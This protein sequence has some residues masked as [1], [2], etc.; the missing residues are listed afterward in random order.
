VR[1]YSDVLKDN[2]VLINTIY[3]NC[4]DYCPLITNKL[5]HV[6][7]QLGERFG[8]TVYFVSIST[9]PL[10][11]TPEALAGFA[12]QQKADGSGW[13]F[14]TGEKQNIET[15]LRKLGQFSPEVESHSTLLLAGNVKAR[16]WLKIRPDT[17]IAGIV[18]E[19]QD[20]ADGS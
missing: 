18:L 5:T 16:R 13:V 9:D 1:F 19:L 14:L 3:T 20:L 15:I 6:R 8:K 7:D 10:R 2:V 17:P 11:D 4:R 12:R